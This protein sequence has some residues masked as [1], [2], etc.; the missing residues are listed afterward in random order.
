MGS[1]EIAATRRFEIIAPTTIRADG[2]AQRQI[3]IKLKDQS[4]GRF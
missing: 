4:N 3:R 1:A 2:G